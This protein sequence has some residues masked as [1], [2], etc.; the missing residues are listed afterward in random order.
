MEFIISDILV[1]TFAVFLLLVT[2]GPG[3]LSTAGVGSGFGSKAGLVYLIGLFLGTNLVAFAVVGGY[4]TLV[5]SI[6]YIRWLLMAGSFGYLFWLAL[7]I[8]L[9]GRKLNWIKSEKSPGIQG[10]ILLQVINP[11]A[12]VVG[13]AIFSGFPF[14]GVSLLEETLWKF[15]IF[16]LVWIPI[17]FLWLFAGVTLNRM[18]LSERHQFLINSGMSVAM[19]GVVVL[20]ALA[21]KY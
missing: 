5:L 16:N 19:V 4:A 15:L 20:A 10:G 11:K 7:K 21:Q 6:P 1:F 18:N 8:A 2:P 14:E 13:T 12:Y 9:A 17:H 3:V